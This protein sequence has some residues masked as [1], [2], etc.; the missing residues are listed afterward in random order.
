MCVIIQYYFVINLGYAFY[1]CQLDINL[2]KVQI[3]S[4]FLEM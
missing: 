1:I 3:V 2:Y 4:N